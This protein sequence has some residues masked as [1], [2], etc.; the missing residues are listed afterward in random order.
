MTDRNPEVVR[1]GIRLG[2]DRYVNTLAEVSL[3][4]KGKEVKKVQEAG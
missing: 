1:K 4:M 3:A 2:L